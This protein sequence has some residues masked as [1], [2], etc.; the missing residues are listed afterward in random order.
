[1]IPWCMNRPAP[2]GYWSPAGHPIGAKPRFRWR[3]HRMSV[4]CHANN[5][6]VAI[7]NGRPVT[8]PEL[9]GW[10]CGGCRW[11]VPFNLGVCRDR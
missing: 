7:V 2:T 4:R 1:M 9:S 5:E 8:S 10:E 3:E 11:F 6:P